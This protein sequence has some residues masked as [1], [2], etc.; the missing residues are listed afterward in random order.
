MAYKKQHATAV[1][2]DGAV[3][4]PPKMPVKTP[5]SKELAEISRTLSQLPWQQLRELSETLIPQLLNDRMKEWEQRLHARQARLDAAKAQL[6]LDIEAFK[7]SKR[8][9]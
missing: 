4:P 7:Q 9:K 8:Q 6:T 2:P 3:P 1:T 5:T